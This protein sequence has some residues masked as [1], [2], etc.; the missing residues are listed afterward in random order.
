MPGRRAAV[1]RCITARVAWGRVRQRRSACCCERPRPEFTKQQYG[2]PC[3]K[4]ACLLGHV[5]HALAQVLRHRLVLGVVEEEIGAGNQGN[6][7][8]LRAGGWQGVELR[9]AA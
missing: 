1:R 3:S 8:G 4:A 5:A 6:P 7:V 2:Q 9:Q